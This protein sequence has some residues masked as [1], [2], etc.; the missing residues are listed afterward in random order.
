MAIKTP[1]YYYYGAEDLLVEEAASSLKEST[2]SG[3]LDTLNSNTYYGQSLN[4]DS[5]I[6]EA[7]TLPAMAPMR[8]ILV[9]EAESIKAATLKALAAY[10]EDP[11]PT[12][13][14]VF[15]ANTK[16]VDERT[17]FF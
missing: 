16:K 9:K 10:I 1:L 12:T 17:A 6:S 3:V 8:F 13:C 11:S 5:L 7:L 2:L 4:A 15:T 14:L